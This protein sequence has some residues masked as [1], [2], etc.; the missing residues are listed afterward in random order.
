MS[1]LMKNSIEYSGPSTVQQS[2]S[3]KV[4]TGSIYNANNLSSKANR[5]QNLKTEKEWTESSSVTGTSTITYP[6]NIN[7]MFIIVNRNGSGNTGCVFFTVISDDHY[8]PVSYIR[9]GGWGSSTS[10][11][12]YIVKI[13]RQNREVSINRVY[14]QGSSQRLEDFNFII[15]YR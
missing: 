8:A 6:S 11:Y 7:E 15:K 5:I 13:D 4:G 9:K 12:E 2:L 10:Y 3:M 14:T 1:K